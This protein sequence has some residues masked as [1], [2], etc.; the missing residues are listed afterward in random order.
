M[1][2]LVVAMESPEHTVFYV[3]PGFLCG[4]RKIQKGF[5]PLAAHLRYFSPMAFPLK[6]SSSALTP[7]AMSLL[8]QY[9]SLVCLLP[10]VTGS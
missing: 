3:D 9:K 10:C 1:L 7:L 5:F 8:S 2:V 6:A 4:N